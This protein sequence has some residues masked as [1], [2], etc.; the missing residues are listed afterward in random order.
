MDKM[1][2]PYHPNSELYDDYTTGD[3]ICMDCGLVIL[4]RIPFDDPPIYG[5]EFLFYEDLPSENRTMLE[6]FCEKANLL[7]P[8]INKA[9][10]YLEKINLKGKSEPL[11]CAVA[12]F[13]ACRNSKVPRTFAEISAVTNVPK[14]E[15]CKYYKILSAKFG[16]AERNVDT[17]ITRICGNLSIPYKKELEITKKYEELSA[18]F[19]NRSP[20][21]LIGASI[22]ECTENISPE[23]VANTLGL[24]KTTLLQ[25]IRSTKE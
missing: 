22:M 13:A 20:L 17:S 15:I 19:G 24:H 21:T 25:F 1:F 4:D 8:I 5:D 6:E 9:T 16:I 3:L 14:K 2:C 7:P 18:K 11:K 10:N 12:I 23:A